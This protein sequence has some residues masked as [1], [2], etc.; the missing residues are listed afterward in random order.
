MDGEESERSATAAG[1]EGGRSWGGSLPLKVGGPASE[2]LAALL[3]PVLVHLRKIWVRKRS[4]RS[5]SGTEGGLGGRKEGKEE[6]EEEEGSLRGG[7]FSSEQ[8]TLQHFITSESTYL[9]LCRAE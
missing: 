3:H 2:T 7:L 9:A 1:V 5:R 4:R 8:N 6:E